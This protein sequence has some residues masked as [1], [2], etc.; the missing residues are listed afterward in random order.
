MEAAK[1]QQRLCQAEET[2]PHPPARQKTEQEWDTPVSYEIHQLPRQ[3]PGGARP[4]ADGSGGTEQHPGVLPASPM[5]AK[6]GRA[7]TDWKLWCVLSWHEQ[8]YS[9]VLVRDII[10]LADNE[11]CSLGVSLIDPLF[12]QNLWVASL[13]IVISYIYYWF[14]WYAFLFNRKVNPWSANNLEDQ[15]ENLQPLGTGNYS[16]LSQQSPS[17][18]GLLPWSP[19]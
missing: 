18:K 5:L 12:L 11:T 10:S 15:T 1:C 7:D 13:C 16:L 6:H 14:I 9:R 3:G 19:P 4:A 8:Q 17:Q 2:H